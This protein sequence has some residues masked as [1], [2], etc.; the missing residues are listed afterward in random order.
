VGTFSFYPTKNLGAIGDAGALA[1]NDSAMAKRIFELRQYG[2]TSKYKIDL[3]G[4]MNSR[5]DE[6]QA[7]VLR[8][9]LPKLDSSNAR[10]L[11]IV[12]QYSNALKGTSSRLITSFLP[13][14]V[15]HLAVLEVA[16]HLE[17][18][19]FRTYMKEQGIQTD[20]HYPILDSHQNGLR[21][22]VVSSSLKRSEWASNLIVSIPLFPELSEDEIMQIT[23]ALKGFS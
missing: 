6:I 16:S 8:V 17:R 15:A 10:R 18:D 9:D 14:N 11:E 20:I 5:L 23:T 22:P 2:W 1:T 7:A 3:P 4:G 12:A 21:V 19:R 13:G